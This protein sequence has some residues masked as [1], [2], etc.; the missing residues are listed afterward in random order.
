MKQFGREN[1]LVNKQ[2]LG[3]KIGKPKIPI[4]LTPLNFT[5]IEERKVVSPVNDTDCSFDQYN[6]KDR[7]FDSDSKSP[8][9]NK[10]SHNKQLNKVHFGNE[11]KRRPIT[12]RN[13]SDYY[14]QKI[15]GISMSKLPKDMNAM[16]AHQ[17]LHYGERFGKNNMNT[18]EY[19]RTV[20]SIKM[21][22]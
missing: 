17:Q 19:K 22:Q 3:P 15:E 14:N 1:E 9:P 7:D 12:W 4:K 6:L 5:K 16:E 18:N 11:I 21:F 8:G 20:E 10:S 13:E 2:N